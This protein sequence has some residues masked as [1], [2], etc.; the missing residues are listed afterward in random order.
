[1][2]FK[3][4]RQF[5]ITSVV[6]SATLVLPFLIRPKLPEVSESDEYNE[7][8]QERVIAAEENEKYWENPNNSRKPSSLE[9]ASSEKSTSQRDSRANR[10]NQS[11]FNDNID[12]DGTNKTTYIPRNTYRSSNSSNSSSS[13]PSSSSNNNN[14]NNEVPSSS[15]SNSS[16]AIENI[17]SST[18]ENTNETAVA[19]G[20]SKDTA[21][22]SE[23]DN[24]NEVSDSNSSSTSDSNSNLAPAISINKASGVYAIGPDIIIAGTNTSEIRY[25]LS[26]NAAC[27]DPQNGNEYSESIKLSNQSSYCLQAIGYNSTG[28]QTEILKYEYTVDSTV[29]D[30]QVTG[31]IQMQTTEAMNTQLSSLDFGKSSHSLSFYRAP[32][33]TTD[34]E[35]VIDNAQDLGIHL[36]MSQMAGVYSLDVL[37]NSLQYGDNFISSVAKNSTPLDGPLIS[38]PT[39]NIILRDFDY[40]QPSSS[41]SGQVSVSNGIMEFQGHF[42]SFGHFGNG[43]S[44]EGIN[45]QAG[46]QLEVGLLNILN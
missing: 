15:N 46:Q 24:D 30:V 19:T 14:S 20:G 31:T 29:P 43:T 27:C 34:C 38:C 2:I 32:A 35:D 4:L 9:Q 26:E 28:G 11:Q 17:N 37:R 21:E 3:I 22:A 33:S 45:N 13:S 7:E 8:T 42:N 25:C 10:E 23:S 39:T 44:G 36:D 41:S 1:M 6:L 16:S 12:N 40:F 18:S 5:P